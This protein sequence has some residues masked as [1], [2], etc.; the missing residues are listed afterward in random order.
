MG[1]LVLMAGLLADLI[2]V[3]R[4][5]LETTLEKVRRLEA[6]R[7]ARGTGHDELRTGEGG[8]R[9]L[10]GGGESPRLPLERSESC[11]TAR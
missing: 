10:G 7:A 11:G 4:Q 3:N 1:F 2:A 8:R 5:F 6:P 9:L